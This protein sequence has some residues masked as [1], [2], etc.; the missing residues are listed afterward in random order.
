VI[1]DAGALS[2]L[3]PCG[4]WLDPRARFEREG[5]Q[6]CSPCCLENTFGVLEPAILYTAVSRLMRS[7]LV[8]L[9]RPQG[10]LLYGVTSNLLAHTCNSLSMLSC[11]VLTRWSEIRGLRLL[12]PLQ[13]KNRERFI[14]ANSQHARVLG[15]RVLDCSR[16]PSIAQS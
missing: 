4:L 12:G 10:V 6:P 2:R 3:E 13:V 16:E 1:V 8:S 5:P 15:G 14:T 9:K 7:H 11:D